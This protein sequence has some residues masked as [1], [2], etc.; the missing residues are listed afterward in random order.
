MILE[1]QVFEMHGR[2]YFHQQQFGMIRGINP[3]GF[4]TFRWINCEIGSIIIGKWRKKSR[5]FI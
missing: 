4:D 1:R 2:L 5:R 3:I